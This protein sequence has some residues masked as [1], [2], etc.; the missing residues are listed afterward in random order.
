MP[1][2]CILD[3]AI[4]AKKNYKIYEF[5]VT[6]V[7]CKKIKQNDEENKWAMKMLQ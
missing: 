2:E 3:D 7:K 6:K 4:K 1:K 5:I